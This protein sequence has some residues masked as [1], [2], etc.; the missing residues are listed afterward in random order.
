MGAAVGD[1]AGAVLEFKMLVMPGEVSH[2]LTMPG[3]GPHGV[4]KGQVT[5]DTEL[6]ICLAD[7]L[8]AGS[9]DA[10]AQMY[11]AWLKSS[12][13]DYGRT[14]ATA[15]ATEATAAGMIRSAETSNMYS[16]ANG[17][18]MRITP[19]IVYGIKFGQ[20]VLEKLVDFDAAMSHPNITT[21]HCN[22]VYAVA[23]GS[24]LAR[25][26][27]SGEAIG[28]ARATCQRLGCGE[29]LSWLDEAIAGDI[30]DVTVQCGYVKWALK[31]A[32]FHLHRKSDFRQAIADT[33]GRGGDTDTNAAVV[34]GMLGAF[35]GADAL[36]TSMTDP[37]LGF[38]CKQ[39][40][41][42]RPGWLSPRRLPGLCELLWN[43][44][45]RPVWIVQ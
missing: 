9:A 41:R 2:A 16:K 33:I 14:C 36:P 44:R 29:I 3:G 24:L 32:F 15:F 4:G 40:G 23:V 10:V 37:V 12:P 45:E 38:D 26:K 21:R 42:S 8:A 43:K 1:A 25:S 6:A 22:I 19:A 5:D 30:G 35:W 31:L 34:G 11:N 27:E 13:F 7:G 39:G 28:R 20:A 18:M 17:A